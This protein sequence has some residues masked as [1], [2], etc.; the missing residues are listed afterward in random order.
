MNIKVSQ[1]KYCMQYMCESNVIEATVSLGSLI[2]ITLH[3]AERF[4]VVITFKVIHLEGHC[5]SPVI[6]QWKMEKSVSNIFPHKTI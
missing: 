2:K 5:F 3:F 1:E 6:F 4:K